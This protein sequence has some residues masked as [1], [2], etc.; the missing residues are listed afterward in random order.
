[1]RAA[2]RHAAAGH[3]DG[4]RAAGPQPGADDARRHQQLGPARAGRAALRRRRPRPA[5]R[6]APG[7]RWPP[8]GEVAVVLL[9]HGHADHSE[10]A[11]RL[12]ELTGA[13]VRALDPAHRLG[14]EGLGE[15]DVVARGR[16]SRSGCSRPRATPPTR[17][18]SCSTTPCSPATPSSAAA[19]TVVAHP[20]GVLG[21]YLR[22]LERL[23][24]LGDR[25]VLPGHG[26]E[27]P[28]AGEAAERYLAHRRAAARAGRGGGGGGAATPRGGG[29]GGVRRRRPGA[30]A[31]RR[32]VGA[33]PARP[34]RGAGGM[35]CPVCGTPTVPGRPLLLPLRHR[36]HARR[37]GDAETERR[38]VTV[39]FGDLSDFTSWAEDLDP[40]R[41]GVV[42]DRVLASLA[43]IVHDFGGHVDK[44]TGD[45]IMA[46]FGAPTA[47]EDDAE[48][49]VRAA[50]Q[51][52]AVV[53]RLV[54]EESGGGRRLGLRVGPQHRRGARRRAGLAE[55][56]GHRRRGEHGRPAVRRGRGGRGVRGPHDRA[57]DRSPPP[58]GGRWRRCASRASASPSRRTSWWGC[59]RR[60]AA[61]S[62]SAT[63]RRSSA[64]TGSS[65]RSSGGCS[66]WSTARRPG[67]VLVTG[68][69]GV[70][71]S[72]LAQEVVA[73]RRRAAGHA[74][75][76]G[77]GWRRTAWGATSPRWPRW[78]ARPAGSSTPTTSR[79]P[80]SG[81]CARCR[82]WSTPRSPARSRP[83]SPSGCRR[84]SGSPTPSR[85]P[86][87]TGRRR[88]RRSAATRCG[89]PWRRSS[90]R[91]PPTPR[92]CSSSTTCT[93]PAARCSRAC[94]TSPGRCRAGCCC[95][96]SAARSC[97][98]ARCRRAGGS[99]LPGPELVVLSP[100]EES[101]TERL[102]RAYLGVPAGAI[103]SEVRDTL[104]QPGAGQPVLPRR[105]AAPARRP[106]GAAP[107]RRAVGARRAGVGRA[108]AGR[109]A[110]RARGPH[111]RARRRRQGGAARRQRPRARRD[112]AGRSRRWAGR[113]GTASRRWW[114]R[115]SAR[116]LQR[117]LLEHDPDGGP[118]VRPHAGARRRVRRAGQGR[119]GPP[120]RGR[121]GAH[122]RDRAGGGRRCCAAARPTRSPR[123]TP[124]GRC[125]WPP[126]W[127]CRAATRRGRPAARRSSP[128]CGSGRARS[129]AT[130]TWAPR[131]RSP[132]RWRSTP[133]RT[134]SGCRPTSSCRRGWP[135]PRRWSSLHRLD[136][137]E[138]EL[139]PALAAASRACGPARCRCWGRSGGGAATTPAPGRPSCR[140]WPPRARPGSTGSPARRCASSGC[141]TT[142]TAGCA[143][144][145][146][147]SGRPTRSPSRWTTR[148]ARAGRC[149]TWRGARRPA[150]TTRWPTGCSSRPREVFA[151]LEDSG[152]LSWVAGTEGFVRLLQG[153]LTEAR[154]LAR[155]VLPLGEAMGERWG[156][157]ALLV[158][159]SLAAAELGEVP[160]ARAAAELARARFEDVGDPWGRALALVACGVAARGA[161]RAVAGRGAARAGRR[162]GGRAPGG[163]GPGARRLR[164]RQPGPGRPRAARRGRPGGRARCSAASTSS[165][166]PASASRCCSRRC[167]AAAAGCEEAL[168]ELDDALQASSEPALLFPRRQALSHRAGTLL[169]L[170]RVDE[171]LAAAR[172]AVATDERGRPVAGAVAA[173]PRRRAAG[174]R[175][176]PR[177]AGRRC[178]R[179]CEVARSTGQ[180]S[181]VVPTERLLSG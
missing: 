83:R 85:R 108:A 150:A 177:R 17:S 112:A 170:G 70:G 69:A 84:C 158:I 105:A 47:H 123:R 111:R 80:G 31:R 28:A 96:R 90:A 39:L 162:P 138:A 65:A 101:A 73:L 53:R 42:T 93:G 56:H 15:G 106:R 74:G 19:R 48:R 163:R 68:E 180:V 146:S 87:A 129:P 115:R 100:L 33:R 175:P 3:A 181:E 18:A 9:T 149:S 98:R 26:P 55:L 92:C 30:V 166:T 10:G 119:A 54:E 82:G 159:E 44:L 110:G 153:R 52:Q 116:L 139:A 40:E 7:R 104:L 121:G 57:G 79:P 51:M 1:M 165:R 5:A 88:A 86:R 97:S 77:G 151:T 126:R 128:W 147:A 155:S 171:A 145:R 23:R 21:D 63:R 173:R 62:G 160:T 25:T 135:G 140:R 76:R 142:S 132:A 148:A 174:E 8:P 109:R 172:E 118:A 81:S 103:D 50:A 152:G 27:L 176:A 20:D 64:A 136:E 95:W 154:E 13:P 164:L 117:R 22:S 38:V 113:P 75:A 114:S 124:S 120:A 144:P 102:L 122:R 169:D 32:A 167:C 2:P 178:G 91:W 72:R 58:P 14:D 45:G 35:T 94:S 125:G 49:A 34:P 46:V 11:A 168:A 61:A 67:S 78:C 4:R 43:S 137:A 24:E 133:R 134:A 37:A 157:A 41:V 36:A 179:R 89:R 141:S 107:R 60:A 130:T 127:G 156:V 12:A 66:T 6:G 99:A 143:T 71:K 161:G 16:A 131:A 29:R 59:G